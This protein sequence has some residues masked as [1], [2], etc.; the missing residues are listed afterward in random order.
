VIL[1]DMH[2]VVWLAFHQD[3]ISRKASTAIDAARKNRDGLVISDITP[4]GVGHTRD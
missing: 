2:V 3:Q 1:V 4:V